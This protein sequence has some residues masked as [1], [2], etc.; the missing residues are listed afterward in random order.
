[1][2]KKELIKLLAQFPDNMEVVFAS[3]AGDYWHSNIAKSP[4]NIEAGL[5]EYSDYFSDNIVC[6]NQDESEGKKEVIIIS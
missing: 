3:P 5:V 4:Q 2:T 6:S 1:M